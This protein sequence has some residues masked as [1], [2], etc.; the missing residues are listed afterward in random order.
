MTQFDLRCS[1]KSLVSRFKM[2]DKEKM[3]VNA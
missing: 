1:L 3:N 2:D